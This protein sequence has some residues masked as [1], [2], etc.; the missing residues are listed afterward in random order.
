MKHNEHKLCN[1]RKFLQLKNL[2]LCNTFATT[3]RKVCSCVFV[4]FMTLKFIK[5]LLSCSD[6][7]RE[8]RERERRARRHWMKKSTVITFIIWLVAKSRK[9][10]L[11]CGW[12][13]K[14][15]HMLWE[16]IAWELKECVL[17]G[18]IRQ[19]FRR[20]F[21]FC[22]KHLG[23]HTC[24]KNQGF[25]TTQHQMRKIKIE[26]DIQLNTRCTKKIPR[27]ETSAPSLKWR[28]PNVF[29]TGILWKMC[30]EE[31]F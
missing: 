2:F 12:I 26:L 10:V 11:L 21:Y 14:L 27:D 9:V 19:F 16:M 25:Q 29:F 22:S 8:W 1:A 30:S 5:T 3:T 24:T 13:S 7:S 23:L 31:W 28:I 15:R 4:L 20:N 6:R 18:T 17:K